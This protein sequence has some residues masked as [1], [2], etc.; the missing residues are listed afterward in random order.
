MKDGPKT[1]YTI[2]KDGKTTKGKGNW[3]N[4]NAAK[5]DAQKKV[6]AARERYNK[7]T[8][9]EKKAMQDA[10]NAKRKAFEATDEYKKRR[11]INDEKERKANA[12]KK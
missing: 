10:A 11:A 3:T 6:D 9:A 8:P 5:S 12:K 4:P 2:T 1:G 7:M